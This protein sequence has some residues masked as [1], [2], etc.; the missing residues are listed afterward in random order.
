MSGAG[1]RA[2]ALSERII[3]IQRGKKWA[4]VFS[5]RTVSAL[6]NG[7]H[8]SLLDTQLVLSGGKDFRGP[9]MFVVVDRNCFTFD[10]PYLGAPKFPWD[11]FYLPRSSCNF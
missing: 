1:V 7:E 10:L 11:R 5:L 3:N 6:A 4:M 8:T 9:I 2:G